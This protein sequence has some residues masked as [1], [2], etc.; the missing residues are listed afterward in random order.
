MDEADVVSRAEA[1]LSELLG[2]PVIVADFTRSRLEV[3]GAPAYVW[4]VA[5]CRLTGIGTGEPEAVAVKWL[6][7]DLDEFRIDPRQMLTERAALEFLDDLGLELAPRLLASDA[8]TSVLVLEDL[9]PR[10][11]LYD[12]L[13]GEESEEAR[14]GLAAFATALGELAATTVGHAATYYRRR[15]SLGPVEPHRD[16]EGQIVQRWIATRAAA[17]AIGVPI[18]DHAQA[19]MARVLHLMLHPGP[20]LAF[21]NGDPGENNFLILG[22]DGRTIDFEFAGYR[23]ALL[24]GAALHLPGPRWI[25]MPDPVESGLEALHRSA[26]SQALPEVQDDRVYGDAMAAAVLATA[27]ERLAD[28]QLDRIA[29]VDRR[30]AGDGSRP[31]VI[32]TLEYSARAARHHVAFPRLAG[33]CLDLAERLRA[34]WPDAD[35]RLNSLAGNPATWVRR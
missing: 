23:H 17:A 34:R 24:D 26:L 35:E 7:R 28:S 13:D 5:R 25:T 27:L 22:S 18:P 21:S 11:A 3:S 12:L 31:Q 19:E 33:W 4:S 20:F 9:H 16:R 2:R 15:R 1:V 8:A 30:P 6:R 14:L 29:K 10:R 32:T